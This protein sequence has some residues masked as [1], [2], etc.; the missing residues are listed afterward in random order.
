MGFFDLQ[1]NGY[2]GI[3]FNTDDLSA[4][5]LH[6]ACEKLR[7]DGVEGILGTIIT[8]Q[9]PRMRARI[10]RLVELRAAD[11]LARQIIQGIHI[12][13]PFLSDLPGYAGA[14]P[15]DALAPATVDATK[16]LL[17]AGEGLTRL[18]TLAPE[19]DDAGFRTIRFLADRGVV[20]SAGHTDASIDQLRGAID[21]GMTMFTHLGNGCPRVLDRHDN[22]VQRV[23]SLRERLWLCFIADGVHVPFFALRNYLALAGEKAIVVTDAMAAAGL[24]P[25]KYTLGRWGVEVDESLAAWA[26]QKSHLLGSAVTMRRA[27]QNLSAQVGMS[28]AEVREL[29]EVRPRLAAG[30]GA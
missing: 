18:V 3:D 15:A 28:D 21:A 23:L 16:S 12:E 4:D 30:I 2:G 20:V 19:R 7:G 27:A 11:P 8:E 14:H 13:G 9:L 25:G 24:G 6:A 1:V 5:A 10:A 17:D 26:P 29:T 22:I